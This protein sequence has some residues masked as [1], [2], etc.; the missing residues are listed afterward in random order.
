MVSSIIEEEKQKTEYI[1]ESLIDSE[2]NYMFTNDIEYM[3]A[4]E[5]RSF[6]GWRKFHEYGILWDSM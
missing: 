4:K 6:P 5:S 3:G 2:I 1:M